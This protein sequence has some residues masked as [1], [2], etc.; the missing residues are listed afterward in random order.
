VPWSK[1]NLTPSK[2]LPTIYLTQ[3]RD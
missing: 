3:R 1:C 2:R